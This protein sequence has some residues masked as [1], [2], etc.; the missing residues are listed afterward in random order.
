[1]K[2]AFIWVSGLR[3]IDKKIINGETL[4]KKFT[5]NNP[6][7]GSGKKNNNTDVKWLNDAIKKLA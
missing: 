1:M 4:K 6:A 3:F 2:K 5:E 7:Q